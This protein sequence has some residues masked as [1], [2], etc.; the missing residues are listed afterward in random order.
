MYV[1]WMM[2]TYFKLTL[3]GPGGEKCED[4]GEGILWRAKT[5][6]CRNGNWSEH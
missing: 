4:N 6:H 3:L 1:Q 2:G 5:Q